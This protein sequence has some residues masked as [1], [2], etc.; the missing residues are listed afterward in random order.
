[1]KT[2]QRS[3][4]GGEIAPELFGRL[5]LTKYQTGLA[6]CRNFLVM[7]H[8]PI[9]NRPGFE[10]VNEVKFSDKRVR[11]IPFSFN[12]EQS[13][14][15]EL[16]DQYL[17]FHTLTASLL[18]ASKPIVSITG[19]SVQVTAHGYVAGKAVFIGGRF[20]RIASITN[21]NTFIVDNLDGSA[22][23]PAGSTAAQQYEIATPY[24]EA[25]LFD[26]HYAQNADVLTLVHPSYAPRELR[27]LGATSWTLGSINFTPAIT[28]PTSVNASIS[29]GSGT[30][31][32]R[33]RVTTLTNA[34]LEESIASST[35]LNGTAFSITNIQ[36]Y[37]QLSITAMTKANPGVFTTA[38]HTLAVNDL[39][40]IS[41]FAANGVPEL[42]D[43][44]YLV[45][46][47]PT[48]TTFSLK[49]EQGT[50]IDTTNFGTYTGSGGKLD[51]PAR[52]TTSLANSFVADDTIYIDQVGGATPINNQY[53]RVGRAYSTTVFSI[54]SEGY[55]LINTASWPAYTTGGRVALDGVKNN[56]TVSPNANLITWNPV[57]GAFRYNVY[58]EQ[59]GIFS[60]IGQTVS[61]SFRDNNISPDLSKSPPEANDPFPTAGA[62]PSA[63]S[64]FDQRRTFA[65][66]DLNP[67]AFFMSRPGTENNFTSSIPTQDSDA[68]SYR[69]AARE[70]N[71][72]RHLV[73]LSDLLLLTAG[74]EWR[75]GTGSGDPVT[76]GTT[77]A[78]VQSYIGANNVQPVV[79][80]ATAIYIQARGARFRELTYNFDQQA[81]RAEDLSILTP[82]YVE[83]YT[84][85]DLAYSRGPTPFVWAI[86]SDGVL[87]AL[88]YLPG[89]DVRGWHRHDT[90]GSF[91]SI[92]CVSEYN[93]DV[94]YAVV[95]RTVNGRQVRYIERL[96]RVV[97]DS[98][99]D[100]FFMDAGLRY[101]GA[102]TAILSGLWHL[103]GKQ[104]AVLGDAAVFPRK[105]VVNGSITLEQPVSK[106]SVG[107]PIIADMETLPLAV[108]TEAFGQ[109]RIKNL[110]SVYLRVNQSSGIFAGPD[111]NTLREF[112]Q[113]TTE[114]Y[115]MPPALFTGELE[116]QLDGNWDRDGTV[117][118][119]QSDPLPLNI[120]SMTIEVENGG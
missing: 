51:K 57:A 34:G 25:D 46:S 63:V 100:A 73:P 72:I 32:Y 92:C 52:I 119:R 107:L 104:V 37:P 97:I 108:Q 118:V 99:A 114:A 10:Y 22:G 105:T 93:E 45:N 109:A 62:W 94:L 55:A 23:A 36:T 48:A 14:V 69:I 76:P 95:L 26:I 50:A 16:G 13:M 29:V 103:E 5:D 19:D 67:Q 58:K 54:R 83:A 8:G 41:G 75:V 68:I 53:Y 70:Q 61:P 31:L 102:P 56:L 15:L 85:A 74:A 106:A 117:C 18:E 120:L 33:Y 113:R 7:P 88:T 87:L 27:R 78:R 30:T 2:L 39:V 24:L 3:F 11:I 6:A 1:M 9:K 115:G 38:T 43:D 90:D 79:T 17:R 42:I 112:K 80:D 116:I 86:R 47:V 81:F 96:S 82:H 20:F 71:R 35:S 66:T 84:I 89:Q 59:N 49:T 44:W 4:A 101:D 98:P 65:A 12:A 40:Y 77:V 60:Y 111:F 64:Y 28:P 21:A 110:N 91:E